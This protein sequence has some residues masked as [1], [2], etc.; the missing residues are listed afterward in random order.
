MLTKFEN[1]DQN[2]FTIL[3]HDKNSIFVIYII[4][5]QKY[6]YRLYL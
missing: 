2:H 1:N 3:K 6:N 4:G 5:F